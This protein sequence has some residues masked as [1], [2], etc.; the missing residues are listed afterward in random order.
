MSQR[1]LLQ[2]RGKRH[3]GCTDRTFVFAHANV[4]LIARAGEGWRATVVGKR[5]LRVVEFAVIL[6][7]ACLFAVCF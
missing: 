5:G 2:T 4:Q 3:P 7:V 6:S 1:S